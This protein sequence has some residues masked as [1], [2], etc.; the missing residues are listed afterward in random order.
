MNNCNMNNSIIDI[1]N[2]IENSNNPDEILNRVIVVDNN[3][4]SLLHYAIQNEYYK[5]ISIMLERNIN[6]DIQNKEGNTVLHLLIAKIIKLTKDLNYK[7]INYLYFMK[8]MVEKD[9][10]MNIKNNFG[11][12]SY[13]I[14]KY[15]LEKQDYDGN[16]ILHMLAGNE[17]FF[18]LKF[19]IKRFKPKINIQNMYGDTILHIVSILYNK[20]NDKIEY[21]NIINFLLKNGAMT[22][23]KNMINMLPENYININ[24]IY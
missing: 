1:L 7:L 15:Y 18:L 5:T 20:N 2:S 21:L 24:L 23:I 13:N 19:L 6:L 14:I 4:N 8:I 16:T 12:T 22:D 9:V 3:G 10:N 17:Y 11:F